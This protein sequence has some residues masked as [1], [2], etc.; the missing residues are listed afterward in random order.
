MLKAELDRNV[1]KHCW[2][3]SLAQ[4]LIT[5]GLFHFTKYCEISPVWYSEYCPNN[6]SDYCHISLVKSVLELHIWILRRLIIDI[7][8]KTTLH[9]FWSQHHL[10]LLKFWYS[11]HFLLVGNSIPHKPTNSER[12][13]TLKT[14]HRF[15]LTFCLWACSCVFIICRHH[16]TMNSTWVKLSDMLFS[17]I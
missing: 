2:A 9:R 11:A 1:T 3:W 5:D 14:I 4:K 13:V 7:P 8:Q 6:P 16:Q 17:Y 10:L 12:V 15:N